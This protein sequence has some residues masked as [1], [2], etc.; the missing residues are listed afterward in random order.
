LSLFYRDRNGKR[1]A[2][3]NSQLP[4]LDQLELK[5]P[6]PIQS[7]V[8]RALRGSY[9]LQSLDSQRRQAQQTIRLGKNSL[10]PKVDLAY[11]WSRDQGAGS[12]TITP[13]ETRLMLNVEIP[14]QLRKGRGKQAQ[15]RMK[16]QETELKI[17][18]IKEKIRTQ[19][20]SLRV[21]IDATVDIANI[22]KDR[23]QLAQKLT[24]AEWTKFRRGASDL[25]L[26]NFREENL[27]ES[28]LKYLESILKYQ[29]YSADLNNLIVRKLF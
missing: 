9:Q 3:Q 16:E 24:D 8:D 1:K 21:K 20:E 26:V 11:E 27:A 25:I 19:L 22:T 23:I 14:L 4:K 28:R 13:E 6:A 7:L 10:L 18:F 2:A 5:N 29:V 12:Q 15:G 17:Q